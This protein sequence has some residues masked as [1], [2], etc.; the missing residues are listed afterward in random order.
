MELPESSAVLFR[1]P[2]L[3]VRRGARTGSAVC[4]VTFLGHRPERDL[5]S[6]GFGEAFL[7]SRGFD[8][9]HVMS[10][11]NSWYAY[12]EMD[13]AM[14]VVARATRPYG[15]TVTYGASMGGYAAVRFAAAVGADAAIALSPQYAPGRPAA[16]FETRFR[17][18]GPKHV[19]GAPGPWHRSDAVT[20]YVFFDPYDLDV[21]H[22]RRIRKFYP[23]TCSVPLPRS[24]H[25]TG[26]VLQELGLLEP[27]VIDIA[28]A[29]F[30][31]VAFAQ[32]AHRRRR[33][34][35]RRL[36]T[37]ARQLGPGHLRTRIALVE[38]A[39]RW[40]DPG[41][42]RGYLAILLEMRGDAG[43]AETQLEL[44]EALL[45][46]DPRIQHAKAC[47]LMRQNRSDAARA[48]ADK[49]IGQP[50]TQAL[51]A[52]L[53]VLIGCLAGA[54]SW[55]F[56]PP[57]AKTRSARIAWRLRF[58]LIALVAKACTH[59]GWQRLNLPPWHRGYFDLARQFRQT[60]Q[61]RARRRS[62]WFAGRAAASGRRRVEPPTPKP[63]EEDPAMAAAAG[64]S[65]YAP[66]AGHVDGVQ[67]GELV[68]WAHYPRHPAIRARILVTSDLG[69]RLELTADQ[70]RADV[71][72]AGH[73]DGHAG[74]RLP[75]GR[76][77]G[78]TQLSLQWADTGMHLM[79]SPL[80]LP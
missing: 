31:P 78:A 8:A 39:I 66:R 72:A 6:P 77:P 57:D 43:Q 11:G 54:P 53:A 14:A 76:A 9:I 59:P 67:G 73:G 22:E 30:E 26:A 19:R 60:E 61:W 38:R 71:Q 36:Y 18:E 28:M 24:G 65:R 70:Y 13:E 51:F 27:A 17:P 23:R 63:L 37:L 34:S 47:L 10:A 75:L 21:L 2:D 79:G 58:L 50:V 7:A 41:P 69:H 32:E 55:R 80:S 49:L 52:D 16:P 62:P 25:S 12:A 68:G 3:L 42:L 20:P 35:R 46:D 1:T 4:F 56:L 44:A 29:K 5:D 64:P 33:A 74:F 48:V 15:R 45:P 40:G